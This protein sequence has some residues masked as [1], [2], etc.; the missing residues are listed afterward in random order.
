MGCG[1]DYGE[2]VDGVGVGDMMIGVV[3]MR[4]MMMMMMMMK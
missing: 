2:D 3:K 4:M 1:G